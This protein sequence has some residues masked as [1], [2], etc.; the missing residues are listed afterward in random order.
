MS[1]P[2][3]NGFP[4]I[5]CINHECHRPELSSGQMNGNCHACHEDE[6]VNV[7]SCRECNPSS[8]GDPCCSQSS[9]IEY[10]DDLECPNCGTTYVA[11]TY[12]KVYCPVHYNFGSQSAPVVWSVQHP[13]R[14]N[15][16]PSCGL[17]SSDAATYR[18]KVDAAKKKASSTTFP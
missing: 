13:H 3:P 9:Y 7:P 15:L 4:P 16:C 14:F 1:E 2:C 18:A 10:S 12:R 6:G 5:A 17:D 8:F 11:E